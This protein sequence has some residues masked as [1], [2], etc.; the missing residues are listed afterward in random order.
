MRRKGLW[1]PP[2]GRD[3]IPPRR[4][5]WS[6][7]RLGQSTR[8]LLRKSN[9]LAK[10]TD[11]VISDWKPDFSKSS[12]TLLQNASSIVPPTRVCKQERPG[13]H[14]S[15]VGLNGFTP[16]SRLPQSQAPHLP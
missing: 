2:Y 14:K 9:F 4:F 16:S 3:G 8:R 15:S 11:H 10:S 6:C 12:F 7:F 13:V 5:L 1:P